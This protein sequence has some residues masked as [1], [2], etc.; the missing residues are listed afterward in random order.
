MLVARR[1]PFH[2][3]AQDASFAQGSGAAGPHA[4]GAASRLARTMSALQVVGTLLAIPVGV[5]SGYSIYRTNFSVEATCR[6]LRANIVAMLDKNVDAA[7]RRMLVRRDIEAFDQSC[8][9]VDPDAKAA[10][11]ALLTADKT[12]APVA[13]APRAEA[14]SKEAIHKAGPRADVAVRQPAESTASVAAETEPVQ[15]D[16]SASDAAWLAAVRRAL[17]SHA[18]D[19]GPPAN[20]AKP[21]AARLMQTGIKPIAPDIRAVS[22]GPA[23]VVMPAAPAPVL[24]PAIAVASAPAP[25]SDA[26]HPVPP[27]P[28]PEMTPLPNEASATT[29]QEH[30]RSRFRQWIAQIPLLG[31]TLDGADARPR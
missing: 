8:A 17:V 21:A 9:A 26:D 1:D 27:V 22:D 25:K 29:A 4:G 15:R 23:Q 19:Q 7:T 20:A 28:I 12:A 18:A 30:P 31:R 3:G 2:P 16:A 5:A 13:T 24:P 14:Q 11:T 10:F 6:S